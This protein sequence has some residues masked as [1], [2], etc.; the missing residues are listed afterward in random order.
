MCSTWCALG[1]VAIYGVQHFALR[2]VWTVWETEHRR[3]NGIKMIS[4]EESYRSK[5]QWLKMAFEIPLKGRQSLE[6]PTR[7]GILDT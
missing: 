6:L 4:G 3:G 5:F 7:H 1:V 2:N